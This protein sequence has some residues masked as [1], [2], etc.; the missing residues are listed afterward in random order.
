[1]CQVF[2]QETQ[3]RIEKVARELLEMLCV[4]PVSLLKRKGNTRGIPYQQ[5]SRKKTHINKLRSG[6]SRKEVRNSLSCIHKEITD[7]GNPHWRNKAIETESGKFQ[8]R[9]ER[10]QFNF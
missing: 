9:N 8:L 5:N 2:K 7:K 10:T 1:M 4:V 3:G 6:K